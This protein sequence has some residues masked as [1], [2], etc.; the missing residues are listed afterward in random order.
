MAAFD[1]YEEL[2]LEQSATADDVDRAFRK[3][4]KRHHPDAGGDAA[5]FGAL[6]R[7]AKILRDG[8]SRKR[9][10]E[11]GAV[12]E[13]VIDNERSQVL[14]YI[15]TVLFRV[16][17]ST[18]EIWRYDVITMM[19]RAIADDMTNAR[20]QIAALTKRVT[21]LERLRG[22]FFAGKQDVMTAML[23]AQIAS[24]RAPVANVEAG[25]VRLGVALDIVSDH[26]FRFDQT[27]M[28]QFAA[29]SSVFF[30]ARGL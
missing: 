16:I 12:D 2:G 26:T 29:N 13:S 4:A 21:K 10:D 23:D 30:Q 7:A 1:P 9:F 15:S 28:V 8:D 25:L 20:A 19:K 24:L 11:T 27:P 14:L 17:D 22:R 3:R 18:E 6:V 5:R